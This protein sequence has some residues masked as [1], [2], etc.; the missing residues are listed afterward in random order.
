MAFLT[1]IILFFFQKRLMEAYPSP[2]L[3]AYLQMWIYMHQ[4]L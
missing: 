2:Q 4:Y 1:K 3:V